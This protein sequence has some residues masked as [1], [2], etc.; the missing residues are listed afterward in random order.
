MRKLLIGAAVAVSLPLVTL[1]HAPLAHA[2]QGDLC[3]NWHATTQDSNGQTLT[4][5][6]LPDSGHLMYW[7]YGGAQDS[8][9]KT[10]P[11][12][13]TY[14]QADCLNGNHTDVGRRVAARL[15]YG[16]VTIK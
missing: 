1:S 14:I 13:P 15:S 9:W 8:G 6:H 12:D 4:R 5:T 16:L 7:E 3:Y 11:H 2:G 10:G